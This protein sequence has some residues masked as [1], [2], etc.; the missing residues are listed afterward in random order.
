MTLLGLGLHLSGRSVGDPSVWQV[1][2]E[3]REFMARSSEA[4][5]TAYEASGAPADAVAA[6]VRGTTRF[7]VP[8]KIAGHSLS[9]E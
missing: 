1:S 3:A 9:G 8:E 5:G 7:Y 6:A 2:D 4:W